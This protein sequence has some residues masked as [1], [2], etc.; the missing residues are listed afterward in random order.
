[1]EENEVTP[2]QAIKEREGER[3]VKETLET[4]EVEEIESFEDKEEFAQYTARILFEY[5]TTELSPEQYYDFIINHGSRLMLE[6]I[7]PANK[8]NIIKG[9]ANVQ[10]QLVK[11]GTTF[12]DYKISEVTVDET[13][14]YAYFYRTLLT[15]DDEEVNYI[16]TIVKESDGWKFDADDLSQGYIEERKEG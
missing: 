8:E 6:D 12:T 1:L 11:N 10:S 14:I 3:E 9:Y 5:F 15:D 2:E 4:K 7:D 13:G 16:T